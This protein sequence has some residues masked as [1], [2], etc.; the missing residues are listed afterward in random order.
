MRIVIIGSNGFVGQF[1]T[2]HFGGLD[3][4]VIPIGRSTPM[5]ETSADVVIDC[6]GDAR[7]FW[8]NDNPDESYRINVVA[9]AERLAK[10]SYGR[11][12]YL[13]TIDV[14]GSAKGDPGANT[15]DTPIAIDG[16]DTYGLHKHEAEQMV[17]SN[18]PHHLILRAGTLIGPGLRKNPIFD[19]LNGELIRQTPDST[20]S[21]IT[22]EKLT[23]TLERLLDANA[24]GTYNIT[25]SKAVDVTTM[26]RRV[27]EALGQDVDGHVFHDDLLT[28][29]Y[30]ISIE[31][32][33]T[34]MVLPDSE[35]ML[36]EYLAGPR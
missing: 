3:N 30:D 12:V 22:L 31:K 24:E 36:T 5:P 27:N 7:R 26:L 18:A 6:N 8:A 10:L 29:D 9:T 23:Q 21:L 34:H 13:S 35:T 15:E 33:S 1:M 14:Y 20:L 11:Y 25:G 16:L 2:G 4:D 19:A 28:T 17:R 32:I